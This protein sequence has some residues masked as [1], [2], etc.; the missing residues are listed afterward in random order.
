MLTQSSWA[1]ALAG[2][3]SGKLDFRLV[4]CLKLRDKVIINNELYRRLDEII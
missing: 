1:Q 3:Y 2:I 4:H